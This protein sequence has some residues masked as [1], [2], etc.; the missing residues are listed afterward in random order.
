M[1]CG[2]RKLLGDS[3]AESHDLRDA[4]SCYLSG[5]QGSDYEDHGRNLMTSHEVGGDE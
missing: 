1:F 3:P 4:A 2:I 5:Y